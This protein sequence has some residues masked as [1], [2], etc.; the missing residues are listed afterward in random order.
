MHEL[1]LG[2]S[3]CGFSLL[4]SHNHR[5]PTKKVAYKTARY[6]VVVFIYGKCTFIVSFTLCSSFPQK[7]TSEIQDPSKPVEKDKKIMTRYTRC[8]VC[9]TRAPSTFAPVCQSFHLSPLIK[10]PKTEA[11]V[12]TLAGF[13]SVM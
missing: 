6:S 10:L 2:I 9:Y 8:A 3:G 7:R 1:K 5:I 13:V 11:R 4:D 12:F